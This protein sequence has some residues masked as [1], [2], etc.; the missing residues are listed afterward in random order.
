MTSMPAS[1]NGRAMSFAPRSCPSRPGVAMTTLIFRATVDQ[2][3]N[4][5]LT[6]AGCSPSWPNPGTAQ[7]GY[8]LESEDGTLLVDCGPGV[9][10]RLREREPWPQVAAIVFSH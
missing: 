7:S 1:R 8:R 3:M 2:Y 5:R 4:V 6:V 10:S 9:L